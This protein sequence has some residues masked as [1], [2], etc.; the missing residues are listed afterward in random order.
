MAGT[1]ARIALPATSPESI[2]DY[3]CFLQSVNTGDH[4]SGF[5]V[6]FEGL[7]SAKLLA[8]DWKE[9]EKTGELQT[10]YALI[11]SHDTILGSSVTRSALTRDSW[12]VSCQGIQNGDEKPLS[13]LVCGVISCC[14]PESVFGP[15][16]PKSK[17][18]IA[19]YIL[20]AGCQVQL[21][22]TILFLNKLFEKLLPES[23]AKDAV[24][25]PVISVPKCLNQDAYTQEYKQIISS[26]SG[27]QHY[28]ARFNVYY[29]DG[30]RRSP[31]TTAVSLVEQQVTS[32]D[33][34]SEQHGTS[35]QKGVI[36][37]EIDIFE[38]FQKLYYR[39][40]STLNGKFYGS[41]V[42]C[43]SPASNECSIIGVHIG[44]TDQKGE[45]VAVTLHGILQILQGLLCIPCTCRSQDH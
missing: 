27:K 11:T 30:V 28:S 36:N 24:F 29:C 26:G 3:C 38:K 33:T 5:I 43:H 16:H 9:R 19:H 34:T 12:T 22:I 20:N 4:G 40:S 31:Q 44:E 17:T 45:Y 18:L 8:L 21:N 32:Q 15:G 37:Q 1:T 13:E 23:G 14:G 42:V 6:E 41:P 7:Q 2:T 35:A 39:S 10:D 25:P